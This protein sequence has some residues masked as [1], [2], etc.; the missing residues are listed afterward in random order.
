MVKANAANAL[1]ILLENR[2]QQ[3]NAAKSDALVAL[4]NAIVAT[5]PPPTNGKGAVWRM[6]GFFLPSL[7]EVSQNVPLAYLCTCML[8]MLI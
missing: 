4:V 2:P 1:A 5:P 6:P 3:L 7:P 8:N